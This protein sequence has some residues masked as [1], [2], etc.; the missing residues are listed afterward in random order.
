MSKNYERFSSPEQLRD[1]R[2]V[3]LNLFI[4]FTTVYEL[5]SVTRAAQAMGVTQPA[6]SHALSRL[7]ASL[8]DDLFLRH[9]T[10][11]VPSPFANSIIGDVRSALHIFRTGPLQGSQFDPATADREF[12][13][14]ID[15]GIEHFLLPKLIS[16]L[17]R[18]APEVRLLAMRMDRDRIEDEL[19]RGTLNLAVDISNVD[20]VAL[21]SHL[22]GADKLITV[23]R[24]SNPTLKQGLSKE[25]YLN[26]KH[27]RVNFSH[28]EVGAEDYVLTEAGVKRDVV[29]QCSM[30][31][32]ALEIIK[33][34]DYLV[35]LG[36][37]QYQQTSHESELVEFEFPF[38]PTQPSLEGNLI[39]HKS[40][41]QDPA[42]VW[43]RQKVIE[44]FAGI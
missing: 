21:R 2:N 25:T 33:H 3:D 14:L 20:G 15:I 44:C 42:N 22:L 39:W 11:L 13:V 1:F 40:T 10:S 36:Q 30:V 38:Q 37:F 29:C 32:T 5:G 31:T 23:G 6:I 41:D 4:I 18:E 9:G 19:H 35:T 26:A 28:E 24:R 16:I 12:R 34:T 7:K 17:N 8:G 43:L 27:L